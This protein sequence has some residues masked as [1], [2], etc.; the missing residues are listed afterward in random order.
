MIGKKKTKDIQFYREVGD[1]SFDE[2]GGR[3][4]RSAYGDEDELAQEQ[5][6]RRQRAQL[7]KD[8]KQFCEKIAEVSNNTIEVDMPIRE[9]GF[10]GVPAREL[11]LLQPTTDCL[12]HLTNPPFTVIPI[13]DIEIAHLERVQFGLKNFDL[14]FVFKDFHR[15][16]VHIN[17]IPTKQLDNVK[18]WLD[19]MDVQFTEG[20]ANLNWSEIM[21]TVNQD[22]AQFFMDGGWGF[23]APGSDMDDSDE[24]SESEFEAASESDGGSESESDFSAAGSGSGSDDF[25]EEDDEESGEDWDELERKAA[26]SDDRKRAEAGGDDSDDDR[27]KKKSKR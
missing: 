12:V 26:K 18:E 16:T 27:K 19:S 9:L 8:F 13:A 14:V 10:S 4:K 25:S 23:L 2:T 20:P 11:V 17:T 3:K 5:E 21:K 1:A 22:P 7:N 24:E 15:P 6:E